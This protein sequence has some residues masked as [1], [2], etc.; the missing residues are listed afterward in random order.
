MKIICCRKIVLLLTGVMLLLGQVAAASDF[1][2]RISLAISGGA[3]MGAYEAGLIW[4]MIRIVR[5]AGDQYGG[6]MGDVRRPIEI[7]SITG[8]SAG[9]INTLLA[10]LAWSVKPEAEG[11]F[12]NRIDS[13]IFRDV[14]LTPDVNRLLPLKPDSPLYA[15]DDA[16]LSRNDLVAVA[17][18]VIRKWRQPGTFYPGIRLPMGVTVTRVYPEM[19]RISG[20]E[21]E[22]QRFYIPFELVVQEDGSA[23]FAFNPGDYPALIDPS[24][25]LMPWSRNEVDFS[26]SDQQME[27]ILMTTSAFPIGFGR[28]RLQYCRLRDYPSGGP[29]ASESRDKPDAQQVCPDGYA[30][31]EAEFA[32]GGLFDN[33]PIGLARLLSESGKAYSPRSGPIKY[34]YIDPERERFDISL[35]KEPSPCEGDTPPDACRTLTYDLASEATVL[36]GAVGT[37]RRYEL[38]RELTSEKWRL[39]LPRLCNKVADIIDAREPDADRAALL[40]YFDRQMPCGD[41]LR[42]VGKL[43]ELAYSYRFVPVKTPFSPRALIREGVAET[44]RPAAESLEDSGEV[45]EID[46]E[47]L[48]RQIAKTLRYLLKDVA[49]RDSHLAAD[50]RRSGVSMASDRTL[51]V[52]S[53]GGPITGTLLGAFGA[54]LDY[55]F[56]EFDYYVGIYD[57]VMTIAQFQCEQNSYSVADFYNLTAC[58]DHLAEILYNRLGVAEDP[59]GRYVFALMARRE[60]GEKGQARFAYTP[61]PPEDRDFRIIFEGLNT[62]VVSRAES[63]DASADLLDVER[64]FFE[65]LRDEGFAPTKPLEGRVSLLHR[66]VEAP[67]GGRKSL[68]EH[69]MADPEY[70]S[71]ELVKRATDRLVYLEKQAEKIYRQREPDPD[72]G[73]T[74][75]PGLMGAAALVLRTATYKYPEFS[76]AP[77]TAPESWFLRNAI[78]YEVA[79]DIVEGDLLLRWHPTWHFKHFNAGVPFGVGF[80]GGALFNTRKVEERENYVMAGL[81]ITRL[82]DIPYISGFGI[83]PMLYHYWSEPALEDQTTFGAGVHVNLVSNRVCLS[84]GARDLINNAGDTLFLTVGIKDIPGILYWLSR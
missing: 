19:L 56:R 22:N 41:R 52:S 79:T 15:A 13:N 63:S 2:N 33:L 37:A 45:C 23:G 39:N 75:S 3:S 32:D 42:Y 46:V 68:L 31:A 8:T 12:V 24:M 57:A 60:F 27:D 4:G 47:G 5:Q 14:W 35:E 16:L 73:E 9:G 61:M 69:I 7:A 48:R 78:P 43:L 71:H 62:A 67:V 64:A 21:V 53:R 58:R 10:A 82:T 70:W 77:S 18:E 50:I 72:K 40:P 38:Y 81:D 84:F 34:I 66:L 51:Y 20:I 76:F 11:G 55:K 28:K 54:F 17:R 49:A 36:G 74:A 65:Y 59:K 26:V 83:A 1:P 6:A 29:A 44:C 80:V 25:I 30:L